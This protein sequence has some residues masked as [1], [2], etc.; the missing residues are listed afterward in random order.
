[1]KGGKRQGAGRRKGVSNKIT[2][3]TIAKL[4]RMAAEGKEAPLEYLLREMRA[5]EPV[6]R[7]GENTLAFI[8]R[9]HAWDRRTLAAAIAVAPFCH[10]KLATVEHT[11]DDGG[12]IK[13]VHR[14]E[15]EFVKSTR[16]R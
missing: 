5:K 3:D 11:G 8:T 16:S 15:V 12:P 10:A 2:K 13:H 14:T 4:A 1:M 7:E 6:Q 9:Y